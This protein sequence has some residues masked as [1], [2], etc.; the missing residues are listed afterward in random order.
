MAAK[1]KG[2]LGGSGKPKGDLNLLYSAHQIWLAGLGAMSRAQA[3][4]PKVFDEL[5]REGSKLQGGALDAAQKVVMQAFQ[6]AQKT[7][8]QRVDT[9]KEQASETWDNLEKIFQSRVQR[10]MHQLG[11]PT[12][13]EISALSRRVQELSA[14]VEKLAGKK[15][16][17]K[18]R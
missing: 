9:V 3:G 13:E 11:M 17:H 1:K 8:N 5:M 18:S 6:G 2:K 12:A 14:S 7:V 10:A 16:K 4:A 15:P